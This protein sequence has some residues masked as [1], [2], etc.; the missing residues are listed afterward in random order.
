MKKWIILLIGVIVLILVFGFAIYSEILNS[1]TIGHDEAIA[2]A[3]KDGYIEKAIE[4]SSYHRKESFIVIKGIND[5]DE[6]VFVFVPEEGELTVVKADDGI[7]EKQAR[8]LL[9]ERVQYKRIMSVQLGI[10]DGSPLW[11]ITYIDDKDRLT[12]YYLD[13]KT[14]EYWGIRAVS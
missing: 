10:E 13:F 9:R 1:K 7:T 12:Y 11:E 3:K 6:T 4:T 14:G 2:R 5:E 8:Q